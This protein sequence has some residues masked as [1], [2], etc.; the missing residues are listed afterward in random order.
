MNVVHTQI[1]VDITRAEIG[2]NA[3]HV[4]VGVDAVQ[5]LKDGVQLMGE[6]LTQRWILFV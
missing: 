5:M 4:E 2:V 6:G 3:V 1:G